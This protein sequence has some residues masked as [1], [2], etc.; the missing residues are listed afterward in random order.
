MPSSIRDTRTHVEEAA[1]HLEDAK[2][3][4]GD[5]PAASALKYV[6]RALNRVKERV[7]DLFTTD[8]EKVERAR[9]EQLEFDVRSLGDK[10]REAERT[11]VRLREQRR[12]A[13][14]AATVFA[15]A[16]AALFIVLVA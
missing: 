2:K 13:W 16:T 4:A 14:S 1:E 5:G 15:A 7:D 3:A 9:R 8:T 12:W 10:L 6:S 11:I